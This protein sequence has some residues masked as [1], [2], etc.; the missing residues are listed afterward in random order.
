LHYKI[1]RSHLKGWLFLSAPGAAGGKLMTMN[2]RGHL[3]RGAMA[4][5]IEAV[6]VARGIDIVSLDPFIKSHSVDEN[7]NSA[8][9]DVVQVL[10]DLAAKYDIAVDAPHHISK[11]MA[12]PGNASRGRGAS[13]M[14]DAGRLV[15]TLTAMSTDEAKAFG[16]SEE[17]RRLLI[18]MDSGKVNITPPMGAA[19]WFR[20]V[21]VPLGNA[22]D[23]YPSGDEVQTVEPWEPPDTWA[24]MSADLLNRIKADINAGMADGTRYTDASAAKARAAWRVVQ[25]HAPTKTE[26]QAREVIK[27]WV[28]NGVLVNREYENPVDRKTAV[29]L[30][31]NIG[32]G[33]I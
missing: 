16:V 29:G 5:N 32:E 28:K 15:Y 13:A 30:Y 17:K 24:G 27:T 19:R 4:D 18:R 2:Q 9:D 26:A 22:T 11:G 31:L 12:D 25:R 3:I 23:T 7:S 1:D 14:K 8:I 21:G 33:R 20:L 10:T 6:V